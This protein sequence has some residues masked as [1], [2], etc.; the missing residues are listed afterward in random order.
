MYFSKIGKV[1][2][3]IKWHEF[4]SEPSNAKSPYSLPTFMILI[5]EIPFKM[6]NGNVNLNKKSP[7]E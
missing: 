1:Y 4:E 2:K 6:S 5:S 3:M 7:S